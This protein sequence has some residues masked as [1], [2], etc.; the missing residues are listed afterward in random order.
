[1]KRITLIIVF[2]VS[3]AYLLAGERKKQVD[4]YKTSVF[5]KSKKKASSTR[6]VRLP[7]RHCHGKGHKVI[8]LNK[9]NTS[10]RLLKQCPWCDGTGTRG[11]SKR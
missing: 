9:G 7:C 10:I 6:W 3:A 5:Y 2:V 1:M 11:L 4:L 8:V